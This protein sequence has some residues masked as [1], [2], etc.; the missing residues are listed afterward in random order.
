MNEF[1][2]K[3]E[4]Y[5]AQGHDCYEASR[6]AKQYIYH[7]KR[8]LEQKAILN[9]IER[10]KVSDPKRYAELMYEATHA[11]EAAAKR[12]E[13]ERCQREEQERLRELRLFKYKHS[14]VV[15]GIPNI[16][17]SGVEGMVAFR[18]WGIGSILDGKTGKRRWVLE[19]T[20]MNT[21]WKSQMIADKIPTADNNSGLYCVK[22]DPLGLMTRAASYFGDVCGLL[23][24]R[25]KVLEH[26]DGIVR[27]EWARIMC[28]FIQANEKAESIY[29]GLH[30]SYPTVPMYVLHREQI[31]EVLLR[32]TVMQSMRER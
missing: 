20:A 4:E 17:F 9:A 7:R 15:A 10:M 29:I 25:G 14:L 26:T 16:D 18:T 28:I 6:R 5:R 32:V 2:A 13:E 1:D 11:E 30:Q 12:R 24:L 8:N 23:E 3:F 22:L 31:A 27:A 19:S 21:S